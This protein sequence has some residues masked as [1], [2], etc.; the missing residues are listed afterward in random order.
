VPAT[1]LI[2][3]CDATAT[4]RGRS[5]LESLRTQDQK[6]WGQLPARLSGLR[7]SDTSSQ[8][9]RRLS[10]RRDL[11]ASA[12]SGRVQYRFFT[13]SM[14]ETSPCS[15]HALTNGE[16]GPSLKSK[17]ALKRKAVFEANPEEHPMRKLRPSSGEKLGGRAPDPRRMMAKSAKIRRLSPR[18]ALNAAV[19]QLIYAPARRQDS[20]RKNGRAHRHKAAGNRETWKMPITKGTH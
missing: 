9:C 6:A 1:R 10:A 4:P 19:A 5:W 20:P 3:S 18:R 15:A 17:R 2:Y 14:A 7:P 8:A 16:Q 11:R 12:R 13:S